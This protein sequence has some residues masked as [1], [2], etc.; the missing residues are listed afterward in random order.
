MR[1][2]SRVVGAAPEGASS[3]SGATA[4]VE[5]RQLE[6]PRLILE[7]HCGEAYPA[8]AKHTIGSV[9]QHCEQ[10]VGIHT[11]SHHGAAALVIRWS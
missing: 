8:S 6:H 1:H 9:F 7:R 11:G 4:L 10:E 5:G 2:L 3:G